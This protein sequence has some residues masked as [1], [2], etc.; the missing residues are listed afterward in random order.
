M[1]APSY[2]PPPSPPLPP[3]HT[4]ACT[5]ARNASYSRP[6]NVDGGVV[7]NCLPL[8]FNET[9]VSALDGAE[10]LIVPAPDGSDMDACR[11]QVIVFLGRDVVGPAMD[12]V[13]RPVRSFR[14]R[15]APPE[16]VPCVSPAFSA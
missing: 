9:F 4:C 10:Y 8:G 12:P 11:A 13:F 14:D 16:I 3:P 15:G 6:G 5:G 1:P 2:L 7:D